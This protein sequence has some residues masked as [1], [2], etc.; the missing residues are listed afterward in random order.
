MIQIT[1]IFAI[2]PKTSIPVFSIS[3]QLIFTLLDLQMMPLGKCITSA[4][5]YSKFVKVMSSNE[6]GLFKAFYPRAAVPETSIKML[7]CLDIFI[8]DICVCKTLT[9]TENEKFE[10]ADNSGSFNVF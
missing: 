4:V 3:V 10:I 9:M 6:L 5:K 8:V 7:G 1:Q 2:A